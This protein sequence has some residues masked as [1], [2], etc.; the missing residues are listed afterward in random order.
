MRKQHLAQLVIQLQKYALCVTLEAL[1]WI[2]DILLKYEVSLYVV[3]R[4][5]LL[6]RTISILHNNFIFR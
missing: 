5:V 6:E 4:G 1:M 3:G 2:N